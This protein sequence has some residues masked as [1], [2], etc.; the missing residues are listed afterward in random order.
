MSLVRVIPTLLLKE[1]GLVKTINFDNPNYIGDPINA[2]RIFNEK[3]VDE[4]VLL[5]IEATKEKREP[6]Y[7]RIKEIVSESFMPIAYGGGLTSIEQIKKVFDLG[8]E[9]VVLNSAAFNID[10]ISSASLI[11]GSQSIVISID[12]KKDLLGNYNVYT[13]CGRKKHKISPDEFSKMVVNAGGG[14]IIIQSID[15]DGMMKGY[16]IKLV[17]HVSKS[18]DVPV[19]ALGGAGCFE[20]FKEAICIGEASA[21][22]AGSL[23][24]YKGK[25]K[26]VL[27]NYPSFNEI[28]TL[29]L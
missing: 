20:H 6:N 9:K 8:V 5:D 14:E 15:K 21:V 17:K 29:A 10:L 27:I 16:D 26:G 19:V 28:K 4:L 7:S 22:A 24:V 18:V 3:E 11:Y 2:V 1:E 12:A 13:E 23:F 25:H